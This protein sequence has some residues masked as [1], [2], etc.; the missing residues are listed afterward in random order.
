[1]PDAQIYLADHSEHVVYMV[2]CP[3]CRAD[4]T[5]RCRDLEKGSRRRFPHWRRLAVAIARILLAAAASEDPAQFAVAVENAHPGVLARDGQEA[6]TAHAVRDIDEL[7]AHQ[8][9]QHLLRLAGSVLDQ[10]DQRTLDLGRQR[11]HVKALGGEIEQARR[12][13]ILL[14]RSLTRPDGGTPKLGL[15]T[16]A[17]AGVWE[18]LHQL[19]GIREQALLRE[20]ATAARYPGREPERWTVSDY[21]LDG[22]FAAKRAD[23]CS[24]A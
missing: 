16:P 5:H 23:G 1:V 24:S 22:C 19:D 7:A 3:V 2:R 12:S 8:S 14:H 18:E 13:G 9:V 17:Q 20:Q 10:F 4:T 11:D 15:P 21:Q 6:G